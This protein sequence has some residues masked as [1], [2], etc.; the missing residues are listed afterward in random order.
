LENTARGNRSEVH[1]NV[2]EEEAFRGFL[3]LVSDNGPY[4]AVVQSCHR[5]GFKAIMTKKI[6]KE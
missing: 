6:S 5:N 4:G 1:V 3:K 2:Q